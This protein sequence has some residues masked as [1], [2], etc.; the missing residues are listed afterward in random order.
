[1]T[2][3]LLRLLL[4]FATMTM[5]SANN[6]QLIIRVPIAIP[7]FVEFNL[8]PRAQINK[9][10]RSGLKLQPGNEHSL[11][12]RGI[13]YILS[14]IPCL[15][16]LV[17]QSGEVYRPF[18]RNLIQSSWYI[19]LIKESTRPPNPILSNFLKSKGLETE[20]YA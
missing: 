11:S 18:I 9:A 8:L 7:S 12:I 2:I 6:M 17:N 13:Y 10:N 3:N 19:D 1:M 15:T 20:S 14:N 16:P 4:F 5:S